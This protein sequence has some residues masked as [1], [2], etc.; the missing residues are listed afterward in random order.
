ML[1][2]TLVVPPGDDLHV[3]VVQVLLAQQQAGQVGGDGD[4]VEEIDQVPVDYGVELRQ[5]GGRQ[6]GVALLV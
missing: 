6:T 2:E 5:T 4:A 1:V 3:P